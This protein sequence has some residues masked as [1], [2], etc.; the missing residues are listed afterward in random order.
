MIADSFDDNHDLV[1]RVLAGKYEIEAYLGGGAMG[2]VYRARQVALERTVAVKV[3]HPELAK[4]RDFTAR[5]HREAKA[6]SR[7]SHPCSVG[8]TDF[9]EEADGL[10]YLVMEYVD[11][12]T[13][14]QVIQ[15]EFPI[16][17]ERTA[18]ILVQVLS[19][20][21]VAHDLGIVHRDL[22]PENILVFDGF[23]DEGIPTDTVKVCDFGIA[24]MLGAN[25]VLD[26]APGVTAKRD[27]KRLTGIGTILGTP[28]YMSPEQAE[29]RSPDARSDIYAIGVVLY[30]ML[31]KTVPFEGPSVEAI[32]S[33]QIFKT[34][35]DPRIHQAGCSP[36]LASIALR[37]LQKDPADR[38]TSARAMRSEV[39]RTRAAYPS[40]RDDA[41]LEPSSEVSRLVAP[42]LTNINEAPTARPRAS[43]EPT[44]VES[45]PSEP[46]ASSGVRA[47]PDQP[48]MAALP[49]GPSA[50]NAERGSEERLGPTMDSVPLA[51]ARPKRAVLA[52]TVA[53]ALTVVAT[54]VVIVLIFRGQR[55]TPKVET[56]EEGGPASAISFGHG[57]SSG[58]AR[59][60]VSV[61]QTP[62]PATAPSSLPNVPVGTTAFPSARGAPTEHLA[63]GPSV[64]TALASSVS[65]ASTSPLAAPSET[66]PLPAASRAVPPVASAAPMAVVV[67]S[68][69]AP[70]PF[71]PERARVVA[72]VTGSNRTS[73]GGVAALVSHV[74][75]TP[76]YQSA[77]RVLGRAEA[78]RASM[79]LEIDEDGIVQTASVT[80][81]GPLAS[82]GSCLSSRMRL[83]RLSQPPDTGSATAE[84]SLELLP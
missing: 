2:A 8:V 55:T 71:F 54:M 73:R 76:C 45:A 42:S 57:P 41:T 79:H 37:A 43:S 53:G 44:L 67:P 56:P 50:S 10:L 33:A 31:T 1:G 74:S 7:L 9:G 64:S 40:R 52:R 30:E 14:D 29:G 16:S 80:L 77:L 24:T 15:R 47:R 51:I 62:L 32:L 81:T 72:T 18:N 19:A 48:P 66:T 34:P 25:D 11:G 84:V 20:V 6:S 69:A 23:D 28:A 68:A 4:R 27:A 3:M 83:Q 35:T 12:R 39:R 65:S 21:A 36:E 78:G 13:L 61:A 5:F 58:V 22:K 82:A 17:P 60:S 63:T 46:S 59:P 49:A 26:D 75:F 38:F 70:A